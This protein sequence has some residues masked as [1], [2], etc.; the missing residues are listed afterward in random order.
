[1][2]HVL[3]RTERECFPHLSVKERAQLHRLLAKAARR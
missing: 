3:E 2:N 1:V